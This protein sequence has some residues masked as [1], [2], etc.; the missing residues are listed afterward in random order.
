MSPFD[1]AL[2]AALAIAPTLPCPECHRPMFRPHPACR[3]YTRVVAV[4]T[5]VRARVRYQRETEGMV[6]ERFPSLHMIQ[7]AYGRVLVD[8]WKGGV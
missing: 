3:A 1:L 8:M 6:R 5:E 4:L 7:W 2:R